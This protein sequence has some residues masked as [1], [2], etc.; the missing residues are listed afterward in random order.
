M[1]KRIKQKWIKALRSG[2]YK[3]GRGHLHYDDKYC[4]L[5]VLTELYIRE[6]NGE[7]WEKMLGGNL[8][9]FKAEECNLPEV[10]SDWAGLEEK[11]PL[12]V[13][14]DEKDILE[15]VNDGTNGT[16]P[17]NFADLLPHAIKPHTF[18]EIADLIEEQL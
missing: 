18:N 9:C 17:N 13:I 8:F 11:D 10:V 5:G 12:I 3:Q 14:N 2:K 15:T 4:C 1:N 6:H 7:K 16:P